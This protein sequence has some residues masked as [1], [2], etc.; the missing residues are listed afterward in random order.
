MYTG[1]LWVE[2]MLVRGLN[3]SEDALKD[4]AFTLQK[5]RPD[6]VHINIPSR[7]PVENWVQPPDQEGLLLA[8]AILGDVARVVHPISGTFDLSGYDSLAE[9]VIGIITRHPMREDELLDTLAFWSPDSVVTTL[10]DLQNSGQAKVIER[11]GIRFWSVAT[12]NF[13][14]I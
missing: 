12:A 13:P 11:Y 5:I 2:V 9:A 3:D 8:Q 1:K 7:P 6:E 14:K 4:I 10:A